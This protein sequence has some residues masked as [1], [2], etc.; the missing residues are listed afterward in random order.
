MP[1]RRPAHA[2][3]NEN[4]IRLFHL[5]C[6]RAQSSG[7]Y[8]GRSRACVPHG[9]QRD[10]GCSRRFR[11]V[12]Y[13]PG[14]KL[15]YSGFLDFRVSLASGSSSLESLKSDPIRDTDSDETVVEK[16]FLASMR[17]LEDTLKAIDKHK[18]AELAQYIAKANRIYIYGTAAS[19]LTARMPP[20][21]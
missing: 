9:H 8:S 7:F 10:R 17:A 15:G 14:Q 19:A 21:S 13:P 1:K 11:A 5:A 4:P 20:L 16:A 6:R 3:K 2:R 12:G 18:L